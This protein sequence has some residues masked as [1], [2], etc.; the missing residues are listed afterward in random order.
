MKP[1]FSTVIVRRNTFAVESFCQDRSISPC[2]PLPRNFPCVEIHPSDEINEIF[3][4]EPMHVVLLAID[5][6]LKNALT[7][8]GTNQKEIHHQ[9]SYV[10]YKNIRTGQKVSDRL[11]KIYSGRHS[12]IRIWS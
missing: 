6:L 9:S 5:G 7:I 4:F 2:L 8:C 11:D 10:S 12:K 3:L 1:R